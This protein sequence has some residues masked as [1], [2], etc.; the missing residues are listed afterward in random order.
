MPVFARIFGPPEDQILVTLRN[1]ESDELE[2]RFSTEAR[3]HPIDMLDNSY[4]VKD[5]AESHTKIREYFENMTEEEALSKRD[6][7]RANC[8]MLLGDPVGGEAGE[9]S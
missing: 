9:G 3:L 4:P 1:N 7:M 2:V 8:R 5:D 6:D